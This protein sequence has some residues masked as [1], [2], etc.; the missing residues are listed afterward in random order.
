MTDLVDAWDKTTGKRHPYKVP[1]HFIGHPRFGANLTDKKPSKA[2][3]QAEKAAAKKE[4][5]NA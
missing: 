5:K 1:Q 2:L 4:E 3:A